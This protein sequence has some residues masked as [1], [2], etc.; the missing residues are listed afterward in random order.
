MKPFFCFWPAFSAQPFMSTA[1]KCVSPRVQHSAV[2]RVENTDF[3][4]KVHMQ[5]NAFVYSGILLSH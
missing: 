3:Q 2:H 5:H 1:K 4:L